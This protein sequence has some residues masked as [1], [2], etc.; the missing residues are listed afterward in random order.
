MFFVSVIYSGVNIFNVPYD[1]NTT[2][3]FIRILNFTY[4]FVYVNVDISYD[5]NC[6]FSAL[7]NKSKPGSNGC[8]KNAILISLLLTSSYFHLLVKQKSNVRVKIIHL[9]TFFFIG[10]PVNIFILPR[11]I[12]RLVFAANHSFLLLN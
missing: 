2:I 5:S 4:S 3:N 9:V 7:I 1:L 6:N 10:C 12:M 8:S 11:L